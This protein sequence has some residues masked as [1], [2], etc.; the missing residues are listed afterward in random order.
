MFMRS[1]AFAVL[2]LALSPAF[3]V[4]QASASMMQDCQTLIA[5][6]RAD[7]VSVV[8]TGKNA[9]KNRAGLLAKLDA[10]SADLAKGKLCG[11]IAK[12]NDFR[13]KASQLIASGSI[14]SDPNVGVTGQDLVNDATE[15]ISCIEALVAQSGTT[16]P[17]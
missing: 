4:R 11:A 13:N 15:A 7:T 5:A 12:L 1:V 10:A 3:V 14:N 9:E 6:L 16:C 8:I 17:V 2:L